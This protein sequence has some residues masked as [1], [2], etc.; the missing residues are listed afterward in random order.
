MRAALSMILPGFPA[1]LLTAG[2]AQRAGEEGRGGGESVAVV[3]GVAEGEEEE[4]VP[5]TEWG[6][7]GGVGPLAPWIRLRTGTWFWVAATVF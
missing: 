4:A 7:G 5:V 6:G 3:A 2:G 1:T